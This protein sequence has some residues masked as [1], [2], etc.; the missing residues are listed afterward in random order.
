MTRQL[1]ADGPAWGRR[2]VGLRVSRAAWHGSEGQGSDI[3]GKLHVVTIA[4]DAG[5]GQSHPS[6]P[7]SYTI[8]RETPHKAE[9]L[10]REAMTAKYGTWP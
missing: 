3:A 1:N 7:P 9:V 8:Q 5:Y 10:E 4:Q 6:L 2:V